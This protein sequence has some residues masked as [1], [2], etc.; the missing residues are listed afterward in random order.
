MSSLK[1][2][3]AVV[4]GASRGIGQAVAVKMGERGA[5]VVVCYHNSKESADA[6]V[7]CIEN[8]EGEAVSL[9]VDVSNPDSVDEM[10]TEVEEIWGPATVLVNNAGINDDSLFLRM[11]EDSW[12]KVIDVNLNGAFYVTRRAIR[13]MMRNRKGAVVNVSSVAGV[14]GNAGQVNYASAK[15]GLIAFTR[16]LASE[17]GSRGIRINAVA[18]GLIQTDMTEQMPEQAKDEITERT[19][20]SRMGEPGEVAEAVCFLAS[21]AASYITGEV[22]VIDGGLTAGM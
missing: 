10:F 1:G 21:D 2:E 9:Q 12:R 22:L 5:R 8:A 6:V 18:P 20:L 15:S 17:V 7:D 11:G 13:Q 19:A 16:S 14:S 3:I 4:T